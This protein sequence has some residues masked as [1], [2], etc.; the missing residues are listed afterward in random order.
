MQFEPV[1]TV[2]LSMSIPLL[3]GA[4]PLRECLGGIPRIDLTVSAVG[5]P[6]PLQH[7]RLLDLAQRLLRCLAFINPWITL[8][9]HQL[10]GPS[11]AARAAMT[12][13]VEDKPS[14][15]VVGGRTMARTVP[16]TD[17]PFPPQPH[18]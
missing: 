3:G 16:G 5:A 18:S 1:E 4:R 14:G 11:S 9:C 6:E 17:L 10:Q 2:L 8:H 13:T 15:Q 7:C 12:S